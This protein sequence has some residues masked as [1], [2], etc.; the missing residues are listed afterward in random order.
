MNQTLLKIIQSREDISN[1]L[2]HFTKG[3]KASEV[4][5][6]IIKCQKIL[7]IKRRGYICFTETPVTLLTNMFKL[8]SDYNK[9]MYAPYGI[10]VKKDWLFEQGAR[11]VI[12]GLPKEKVIFPQSVQWR[13]VNYRPNVHDFSWLREWRIRNEI[14]QLS[15]ENCFIIVPTSYECETFAFSDNMDFDIDGCIEDGIFHGSVEGYFSRSY[16]CIS[17]EDITNLKSLSK[18]ELDSL[19]NKQKQSD[20]IGKNLGWF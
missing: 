7:D 17:L 16:K 15:Y 9:P 14:V 3:D 1:Y 19:I 8:F 13:F 10:A 18:N 4:L 11:P 12:Y 2:F 20:N 5:S 6:S